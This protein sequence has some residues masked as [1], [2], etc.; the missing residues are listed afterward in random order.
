MNFYLSISELKAFYRRL[1]KNY[2]NKISFTEFVRAMVPLRKALKK[3]GSASLIEYGNTGFKVQYN[4]FSATKKKSSPKVE[5]PSSPF[6]KFQSA[7]INY[8]HKNIDLPLTPYVSD[9]KIPAII[10]SKKK[11]TDQNLN[12]FFYRVSNIFRK[13]EEGAIELSLIEDFCLIDY[14]KLFDYHAIT[15]RKFNNGLKEYGV[16]L[17]NDEL[18]LLFLTYDSNHDGVLSYSEFSSIYLPQSHDYKELHYSRVTKANEENDRV[19]SKLNK[20]SISQSTINKAHHFTKDLCIHMVS[21]EELKKSLSENYEVNLFEI[22]ERIDSDEDGYISKH[23]LD[24]FLRENDIEC[25]D[26]D[27]KRLFRSFDR[28]KDGFISYS[29]FFDGLSP[30]FA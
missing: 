23:E 16:N 7:T 2:D 15:L 10:S 20:R 24:L 17:H 5:L 6:R 19:P 18:K 28:N 12:S 30:N 27:I 22:F 21:I 11:S 8:H 25:I 13:I 1:D 4:T 3:D 14:F 9:F 29:E 26:S